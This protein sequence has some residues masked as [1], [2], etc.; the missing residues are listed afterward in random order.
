MP[1]FSHRKICKSSKEGR[2][3]ER[4]FLDILISRTDRAYFRDLQEYWTILGQRNRLLKH[5]R[6][7]NLNLT[8][9]N[10]S[11]RSQ[12]TKITDQENQTGEDVQLNKKTPDEQKKRTSIQFKMDD[13]LHLD[14][15]DQKLA[16]VSSSILRKRLDYTKYL[17]E[18]GALS[19][20]HLTSLKEELIVSYRSISG[21]DSS[22]SKKEI[23][24]YFFNR[25]KTARDDD[26][27]RGSTAQG[28]HRDDLSFSLNGQD[29]RLYA[30]QGQQRS[31]VLALKMAE[32]VILSRRTGE[33]PI[34]LLDDVL[35]ELDA[36][37]RHQLLDVISGHQVF[38]TST[39]VSMFQPWDGPLHL[40]AV[41][42]GTV[43]PEKAVE[44][45]EKKEAKK[46]QIVEVKVE[47]ITDKKD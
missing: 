38:I 34:L 16:E 8:R 10:R 30:S 37:R 46:E 21:L 40:Y 7:T 1:L 2:Q 17:L 27:A 3:N 36:S 5:I 35:S 4:R 28:P 29:A 22:M 18:Y 20:M 42:M 33:K 39:D 6:D 13:Y 43:T 32:L 11:K 41:S 24:T 47:A 31:I 9:S 14:V 44:A 26:I 25:L 12:D 19:L 15:W 23:E 45:K